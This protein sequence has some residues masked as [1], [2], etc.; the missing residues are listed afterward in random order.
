MK[1]ILITGANS[2]IGLELKNFMN[3]WPDEYTVDEIDV[4]TNGW[5][6]MDFADYDS[7]VHLAAIVH[8]KENPNMEGEYYRVN[9]ELPIMIANKAKS[10]G[11]GQFIFM[12][13][14][15]V[16]GKNGSLKNEIVIN[17]KTKPLPRTLYGKSKLKA[18]QGLYQLSHS[19]FGVLI[20]RSPM[21]YGPNC[22]G[23]FAKLEKIIKIV[24]IFP[25]IDNKRSM[26]HVNR[27]SSLLKSYVDNN[28]SGTMLV[29]DLEY[30]STSDLVDEIAKNRGKRF[31]NQK[32]W[33][34]LLL[35]LWDA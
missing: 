3:Q 9:C 35:F 31:I 15:A 4:R 27:L 8:R 26:I 20:V 24:P 6:N 1:K 14:M 34:I 32:Y 19:T 25:K 17:K 7:I 21:V 23:N 22:N 5:K 11:V 16:Y 18:E 10:E 13:T 33:D 2:Y 28:L 30:Q 29:Q 12:S